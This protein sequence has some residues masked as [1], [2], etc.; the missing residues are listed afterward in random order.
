MGSALT[1]NPQLPPHPQ[2]SRLT[3]PEATSRRAVLTSPMS[4]TKANPH[5]ALAIVNAL[6]ATEKR[7]APTGLPP[8][9]GTNHRAFAFRNHAAKFRRTPTQVA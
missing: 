4:G 1:L 2:F 9:S 7:S 8:G 3:V 6:A 5:R